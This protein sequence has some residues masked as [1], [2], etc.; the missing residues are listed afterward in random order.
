MIF[1]SE[2]NAPFEKIMSMKKT[3]LCARMNGL[4][5]EE[6]LYINKDYIKYK[7]EYDIFDY[8]N[9]KI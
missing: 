5:A 4:T 7:K 9:E 8:L 2:Y 6:N 1:I 3:V